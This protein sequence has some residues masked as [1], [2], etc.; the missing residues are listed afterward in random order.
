MKNI[1]GGPFSSS[2]SLDPRKAPPPFVSPLQVGFPLVEQEPP[3]CLIPSPLSC[4]GDLDECPCPVP[5]P[6]LFA[7]PHSRP[8]PVDRMGPADMISCRS[9]SPTPVD[10]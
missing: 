6:D 2:P 10:D 1:G 7:F 8:V 4:F 9:P 5:P 3:A